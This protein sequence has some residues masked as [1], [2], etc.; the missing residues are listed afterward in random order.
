MK[1]KIMIV[2]D[3]ATSLM[4]VRALLQEEYEV[5]A[6]K[7]GLQ[8]LGYLRENS[9]VA[10]VLLDMMMPGTSGMDVLKT[11]KSD[12][13]WRNM[14]V[15]FLTSMEGMDFEMQGFAEGVDDFIQKPV[16]ADLLKMKIKRQLYMKSLIRENQVL[17][18]RLR[19]LKFRVDKL[20]D[21]AIRK[22]ENEV[23]TE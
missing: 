22:S 7:S 17:R 4:I 19:Y 6:A 3:D 20:F 12:K 23:E 11:L 14:P 13:K 10:L 8:A 16:Y 2:D 5:V 15:I 21:E 18:D 9:D 1:Q